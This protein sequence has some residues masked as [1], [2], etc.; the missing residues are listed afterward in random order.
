VTLLLKPV[1][2][3]GLHAWEA[4]TFALYA[5]KVEKQLGQKSFGNLRPSVQ[6]HLGNLSQT[7]KH[8]SERHLSVLHENV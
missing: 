3:L 1:P 7:L 6:V 2:S 4:R 5:K 8:Y